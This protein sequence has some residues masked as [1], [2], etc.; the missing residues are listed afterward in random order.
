MAT[1]EDDL[2]EPAEPAYTAQG[3]ST[4]ARTYDGRPMPQWDVL[5][6]DTIQRAW[7]AAVAAVLPAPRDEEG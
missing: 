3:Q 2:T 7:T 5:G 6:D 1:L 4:G